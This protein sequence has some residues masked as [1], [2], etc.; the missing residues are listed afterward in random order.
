M[1]WTIL[2]RLGS[3]TP[4][5]DAQREAVEAIVADVNG[6]LSTRSAPFGFRWDRDAKG[7]FEEIRPQAH[8][9]V[10]HTKVGRGGSRAKDAILE[11]LREIQERFP[12]WQVVYEDDQIPIVY[13]VATGAEVPPDTDAEDAVKAEWAALRASGDVFEMSRCAWGFAEVELLD[14]ALEVLDVIAR[15]SAF[16]PSA[17][18][19]G[20]EILLE[21]AHASVEPRAL[22][23]LA[24]AA[25]AGIRGPRI[26]RLLETATTV[27][28]REGSPARVP[29]DAAKEALR[30]LRE[31]SA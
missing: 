20:A 24:K 2:Y 14:E 25:R 26:Q 8:M 31:S 19:E 10:G 4:F 7:F 1:G 28:P 3:A 22:E 27:R 5:D 30:A 21:H 11:G 16:A 6:R 23:R 29:Y 18:L 12:A 9:V 13:E 15:E 17:W